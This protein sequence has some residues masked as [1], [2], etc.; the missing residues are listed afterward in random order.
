M[1]VMEIAQ[2]MLKCGTKIITKRAMWTWTIQWGFMLLKHAPSVGCA[3][4]QPLRGHLP[5]H[6]GLVGLVGPRHLGLVDLAAPSR[7]GAPAPKRHIG[8]RLQ[9]VHP[10]SQPVLAIKTCGTPGMD[11]AQRMFQEVEIIITAIRTVRG[12]C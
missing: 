9:P 8:S 4:P 7:T 3:P 10:L 5:R 2:H 6:L 1:V 12:G 11:I